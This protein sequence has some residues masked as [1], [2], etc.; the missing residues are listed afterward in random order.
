VDFDTPIDRAGSS[1]FK[2]DL[3]GPDVLPLWVATPFP[4]LF[5]T[6]LDVLVERDPAP[7]QL[8]LVGVQLVWTVGVLAGCRLV[9][10]RAERRLVV[11][12]G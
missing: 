9:Q 5:Q 6:P 3:F 10:R 1:S 2:W 12:G 8:G 7:V 4:S 11:Q